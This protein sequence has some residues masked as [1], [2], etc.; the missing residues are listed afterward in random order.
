M[1]DN[2][3]EWLS[4]AQEKMESLRYGVV[5]IVTDQTNWRNSNPTERSTGRPETVPS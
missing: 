4:I 2:A 5:Q 3:P 1:H